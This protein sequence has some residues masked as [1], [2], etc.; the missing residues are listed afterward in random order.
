M[1][2]AECFKCGAHY[3][4][5]DA[6]DDGI[7]G[8]CILTMLEQGKSG[9]RSRGAELRDKVDELMA[10]LERENPAAHTQLLMLPFGLVPSHAME[11][12]D[13]EWWSGPEAQAA[14]EQLEEALCS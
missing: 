14:I 2:M 12:T 13:D 8:G 4:C 7:C 1:T 11:D 3:E 5:G 10:R 6:P 9:G